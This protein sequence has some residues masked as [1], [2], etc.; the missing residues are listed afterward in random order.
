M[1]HIFAR[2]SLY[3]LVWSKPVQGS[4]ERLS[5]SDCADGEAELDDFNAPP[6]SCATA[7]SPAPSRS[8][9]PSFSC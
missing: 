6:T 3:E 9:A 1:S 8:T 4:A 5:L 2:Q 7:A